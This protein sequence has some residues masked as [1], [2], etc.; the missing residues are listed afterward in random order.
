MALS[1]SPSRRLISIVCIPTRLAGLGTIFVQPSDWPIA[2]DA[3]GGQNHPRRPRPRHTGSK[4]AA[5]GNGGSKICRGGGS[6]IG[7]QTFDMVTLS[8]G[9]VL[10]TYA[11]EATGRR[12]FMDW[13]TLDWKRLDQQNTADHGSVAHAVTPTTAALAFT[14]GKT[15]DHRTRS[16]LL[17]PQR[18]RAGHLATIAGQSAPV[19]DIIGRQG[20]FAHP[21]K[22]NLSTFVLET[23]RNVRFFFDE[24]KGDWVRMPLSWEAR[25]PV[26]ASVLKEIRAVMPDWESVR[27]P[28]PHHGQPASQHGLP[29]LVPAQLVH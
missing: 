14:P 13:A 12:F 16:C 22:G 27:A 5:G 21:Q 3:A 4:H 17:E 2:D 29:P 25:L 23:K 15:M 18:T 1:Q 8:D 26:V 20:N 6:D 9:T 10:T 11:D 7:V 24:T 19:D 28:T